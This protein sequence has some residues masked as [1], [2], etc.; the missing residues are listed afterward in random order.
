[1]TKSKKAKNDAKA[2]RGQMNKQQGAQQGT[3]KRRQ[4][5]RGGGGPQRLPQG[6]GGGSGVI[7]TNAAP[8][9]S[10]TSTWFRMRAG[11]FPNSIII[12]GR[13]LAKVA[14]TVSNG[15][16]AFVLTQYPLSVDTATTPTVTRWGTWGS[17]FQRWRVNKLAAFMKSAGILTTV[18]L[19]TMGF[20]VDPNATAPASQETMMRLEGAALTNGYGDLGPVMFDPAAQ[21]KWLN[22]QADANDESTSQ[23]GMFNHASSTYT[24][25]AI[26]GQVFFD[27]ELEFIDVR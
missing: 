6:F 25:G 21:L 23:A 26:P 27:Y 10:Q 18:G 24:A 15:A 19:N 20:Q 11:N 5:K 13:D 9:V 4:R 22:V 2:R 16:G 12:E 17:L 3:G 1:M 8:S 14:L 7:S